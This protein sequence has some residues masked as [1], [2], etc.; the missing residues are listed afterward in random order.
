MI[1]KTFTFPRQLVSLSYSIQVNM[2][3]TA[4]ERRLSAARRVLHALRP[5][6]KAY[7][8]GYIAWIAP[9]LPQL[10]QVLRSNNASIGK[11]L[12]YIRRVLYKG[13]GLSGLSTA[14]AAIVAGST[15]IP[16]FI[17]R[18]LQTATSSKITT[19]D[20]ASKINI[21]SCFFCAWFAF[22]LLNKDQDRTERYVLATRPLQQPSSSVSL[23]RPRN[24]PE[25]QA[26]SGKTIELTSFA[27][28]RAV[29]VIVIQSWRKISPMWQHHPTISELAR[30]VRKLADPYVFAGSAAVIMWSWFYAPERLPVAYKKWIAQMADI[31]QVLIETLRLCRQGEFVYGEDTGKTG[32]LRPLCR[33][34]S[35]P[36]EWAD[37][38]L[39]VPIPCELYHCGHGRSCENHAIQRFLRSYVLAVKVYM[40][41]QLIGLVRRRPDMQVVRKA[42]RDLARS[43]TFLATFVT[44][45]YYTVCLA[46]TRL[47][48]KL[49][50][51]SVVTPQ[52][53][54][55][56]LCVFAGCLTCG[57]SV[58]LEQA[59][60]R[61]ELS[62][63]VAA[64][65]LSTLLPRFYDRAH[66]RRE[67]LVFA[68]CVTVVMT[69][70]KNGGPVR[71]AFG[72]LLKSVMS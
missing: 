62:L 23:A 50:S 40:P 59:S 44:S 8:L 24:N 61:Q 9:R 20:L 21:V 35:L 47:G 41:L 38:R 33:R 34:L 7:L 2:P 69:A 39:T 26:L 70:A 52:M 48:P 51:R 13:T 64:R 45:F 63:F 68:S 5:T 19:E 72:R 12:V 56:G 60:R 49:F 54:D 27:F 28:C 25:Q 4:S 11:R 17:S 22:G 16:A 14:C 46:R 58:L 15:I 18:L 42:L 1:A 71:G 10:L 31:D 3:L 43:S 30:L 65:A 36:E 53:W 57:W 66:Q 32:L 6:L 55:A 67:Q 29:D 37:P